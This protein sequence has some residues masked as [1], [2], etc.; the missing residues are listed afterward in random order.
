MHHWPHGWIVLL[1][2]LLAVTYPA[3]GQD[4][5]SIEGTVVADRSGAALAGVNV[6]VVGTLYGTV[7]DAQGAFTI[8]QLPPGTYTLQISALDHRP[9][10]R[11]VEVQAG[12]TAQV[13]V[14]LRPPEAVLDDLDLDAVSEHRQPV[15]WLDRRSTDERVVTD[16]A[17][18]VRAVLG[19]EAGRFS[20]LGLHPD[21]RGLSGARLAVLTDGLP[22]ADGDPLGTTSTL[23]YTD[24][25]FIERVDVVKG[26]HAL[27][28]S[29]GA[30][31][32]VRVRQPQASAIDERSVQVG[33]A[34]NI[35]QLESAGTWGGTAGR[36]SYLAQGAYRQGG[37]YEDGNGQIE[38]GN[39]HSA[40]GRGQIA[41]AVTPSSRIS[42][43]GAIQNQQNVEAHVPPFDRQDVQSGRAQVRYQAAWSTGPV[44]AIDGQAY[45]HRANHDAQLGEPEGA[46]ATISEGVAQMVGARAIARLSTGQRWTLDV[47]GSVAQ[48]EHRAERVP[49]FRM[50][51]HR[52]TGGLFVQ[53]ARKGGAVDL[54]GTVRADV[55]RDVPDRL[56]DAFM[57]NA[58]EGENGL[59][60]TDV[61]LSA[62][63]SATTAVSP[64]W[65]VALGLGTAARAPTLLE[66][67]GYRLPVRTLPTLVVDSTPD[68]DPERSVQVDLWAT[69]DYDR[70]RVS[71]STFARRLTNHIAPLPQITLP[72][73]PSAIIRAR[74]AASTAVVV[75][76]EVEA[77]YQIVDR[78][79]VARVG[80]SYLWGRDTDQDAPLLDV[81]PPSLRLGA[82]INAPADLFFLDA[83]LHLVA[84]QDRIADALG[85]LP[86]AGYI[87]ADLHLGLRLPRRAALLVGL[88]NFTG[89]AY[90]NHL[91][92][93]DPSFGAR[94][95][96]PGLIFFSRLRVQL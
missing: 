87:A 44:R 91:N 7:T 70:L 53:A 3:A 35:N 9:A 42:V 25:A 5:G 48:T 11:T 63:A 49:T 24:P 67:Y 26:P 32:A 96:E 23:R 74:Y 66:R 22:L 54:A 6:V 55:T 62:S 16:P 30:F 88:D 47:G 51:A 38:P 52:T 2:V 36:W 86:T 72:T 69:G 13:A 95:P 79:A 64:V 93:V 1:V 90:T 73:E 50:D 68:L 20:V 34:T 31:G 84:Q 77:A 37:N 18:L 46:E 19:A 45:W 21:V 57:A 15:A 65:R 27:T 83:T 12:R 14:R 76:G 80:G 29:P 61:L 82:R 89:T 56:T 75:G 60:D 17:Q 33:Y 8:R 4:T 78:Y 81:Q 71:V 43:G 41:Y 10:R 85:A 28:W 92:A 59:D 58:G 39:F 40:T 94:V